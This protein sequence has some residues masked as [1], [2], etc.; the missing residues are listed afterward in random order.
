MVGCSAVA[1]KM[2]DPTTTETV[3]RAASAPPV[4]SP[5]HPGSRTACARRVSVLRLPPHACPLGDG[6]LSRVVSREKGPAAPRR[7]RWRRAACHVRLR[8]QAVAAGR[9]RAGSTP[10]PR[11][12]SQGT[13]IISQTRLQRLP[14]AAAK[15][16]QVEPPR[17]PPFP[18]PAAPPLG[19]ITLSD[20]P[21]RIRRRPPSVQRH[22]CP[23]SCRRRRLRDRRGWIWW[24]PGKHDRPQSRTAHCNQ[25]A[26]TWCWRSPQCQSHRHTTP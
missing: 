25:I 11:P 26:W 22:C 24:R 4:D 14:S 1:A 9:P 18:R 21:S 16:R 7:L 3:A 23:A 15:G 17:P 13:F 10:S 8:A 6:P 12:R 19:D 2:I 20:T 5:Q